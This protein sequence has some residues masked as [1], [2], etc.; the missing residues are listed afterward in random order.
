LHN[1]ISMTALRIALCSLFCFFLLLRS[2][3]HP[4]TLFIFRLAY[5][6]HISCYLTTIDGSSK[7]QFNLFLYPK[8]KPL[9]RPLI[10]SIQPNPTQA[11]S[12]VVPIHRLNFYLSF[13]ITLSRHYT[14]CLPKNYSLS[15]RAEVVTVLTGSSC[16]LVFPFV[17]LFWH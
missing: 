6:Q 2:F 11:S 13:C 1:G 16:T 7:F 5:F 15:L 3:T 4:P 10:P 8:Q 17:Y 14:F 9:W 12:S